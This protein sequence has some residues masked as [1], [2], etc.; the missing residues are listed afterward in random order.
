MTVNEYIIKDYLSKLKLIVGNSKH[1]VD[2]SSSFIRKSIRN[3]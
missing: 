3:D 2:L 1:F